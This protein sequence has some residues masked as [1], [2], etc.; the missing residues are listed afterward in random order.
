MNKIIYIFVL[1]FSLFLLTSCLE[2]KTENN[3]AAQILNSEEVEE[4]KLIKIWVLAPLSWWA[5]SYW[6]DAVNAY[7]KS[8]DDYNK[9]E[10]NIK[11]ELVI[12]DS[13]C[14]WKDSI[15]AIQKLLNI[16]KVA[17]VLG[18]IC[19]SET[20]AA[21]KIAESK[22]IVMISPT[23]S[24][25]EISEMWGYIY[26]YWND[27]HAWT[28]LSQYLNTKYEKINLI[29]ENTDYAK[30]LS[31]KLKELYKWEIILDISFD[32]HEKDFWIISNNIEKNN[33]EAIV[34]L[35]QTEWSVLSIIK[36]LK[37]KWLIEKY[38]KE[39]II[40]AYFFSTD[41]VKQWLWTDYMNWF[42]QVNIDNE[43]SV[44]QKWL[45]FVEEFKKE[46]EVNFDAS[47][48]YLEKEAIDFV[49]ESIDN[50]V[51][52]SEWLKNTLD[53]VTQDNPRQG[54]F[55]EYYIDE[56]WDAIGLQYSIEK[57]VAWWV[58]KLEY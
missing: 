39:N 48:L 26:R 4:N 31:N 32:S 42:V 15:T 6:K 9:K 55:W 16:D 17:F 33:A 14:S 27:A 35:N 47:F 41:P 51:R 37:D 34:L 11:V 20:I 38:K 24:S 18:W 36:S 46:Y 30:A 8:I 57:I 28:T 58:K 53:S 13:K 22:K 3:L 50:W 12:E 2:N 52:D 40:W 21:W 1:I 25:P 7:R 19:S 23:S 54:Y 5:S 29:V 43:S 49:L 44:A 10:N 45:D 56:K